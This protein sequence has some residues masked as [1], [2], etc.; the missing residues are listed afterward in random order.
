M[1]FEKKKSI[2][3]KNAD[4]GTSSVFSLTTDQ[5]KSLME[6]NG[7][8]LAEKLNSSE[9]NG[10]EGLLGKLEVDSNRGLDSC[11]EQDLERRRGIYGENVI[12]PKPT[13]SFLRLCWEAFHDVIL[14]ILLVCAFISIGLSF[15]KPPSS[16]EHNDERKSSIF[17]L[18]T[19]SDRTRE[20]VTDIQN[21]LYDV[22]KKN[23]SL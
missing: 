18:N 13:K 10:L 20:N 2:E 19:L 3:N 11:N 4:F 23:I 6:L 1:L 8:D 7:K 14:I 5:L 17:F 22:T 21:N 9:F 16:G 15:Y 12:P